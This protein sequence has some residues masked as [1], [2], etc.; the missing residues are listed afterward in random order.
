MLK[1]RS[2]FRFLVSGGV[3]TAVTYLVYLALLQMISYQ[4][5]YAVAFLIG[6][7]MNYLMGRLFVFK[8]HQGVRT[9]LMLP[10]VYFLQYCTSASVVW[11]WADIL[12]QNPALAPAVAI[13]I[14][15]P[16][17]YLM[18]KIVFVGRLR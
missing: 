2:I 11:I 15:L 1:D 12:R 3:S 8:T 10:L 6:I 14:T 9:A 7:S 18:S 5:A 17:T 4:V 13:V 16:M